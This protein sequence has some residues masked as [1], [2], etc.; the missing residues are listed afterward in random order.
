MIFSNSVPTK[1]VNEQTPN[2]QGLFLGDIWKADPET[3]SVYLLLF[4]MT[5]TAPFWN[6]VTIWTV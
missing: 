2:S 5:T 4:S 1:Y 6:L 3:Y